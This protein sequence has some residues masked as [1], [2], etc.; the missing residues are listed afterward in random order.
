MLNYATWDTLLGEKHW[1]YRVKGYEEG[2]MTWHYRE[3][4]TSYPLMETYANHREF[5]L[6]QKGGLKGTD[7]VWLLMQ[8]FILH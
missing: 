1:H 6:H 8:T 2:E 7:L 4:G 3:R 5:L